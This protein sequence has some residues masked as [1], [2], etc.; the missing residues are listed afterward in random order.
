MVGTNNIMIWLK[1]AADNDVKGAT[2]TIDYS[3]PTKKFWTSAKR[4]NSYA[5]PHENNYH[6]ILKIP[7]QGLWDV[8][9]NIHHKGKSVSTKFA[10]NVK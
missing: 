10:I 3:K 4:Y 2:L 6:V 9:I 7:A 1:D 5:L 8:T